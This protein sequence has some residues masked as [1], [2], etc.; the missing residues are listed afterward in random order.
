MDRYC[1]PRSWWAVTLPCLVAGCLRIAADEDAGAHAPHTPAQ[2]T[3]AEAMKTMEGNC[4]PNLL[5]AGT[6]SPDC[7]W[8]TRRV[9][10]NCGQ[11]H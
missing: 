3:C 2:A 6:Q 10:N 4:Y 9:V 11:P 7:S 1:V 5:R 8:E